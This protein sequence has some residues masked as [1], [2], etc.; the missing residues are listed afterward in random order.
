MIRERREK[1][2]DIISL[3]KIER[4][5]V[6]LVESIFFL[7]V[8]F[9]CFGAGIIATE[10]DIPPATGIVLTI[11]KIDS[12]GTSSPYD[13][14]WIEKVSS[15]DFGELKQVSGYTEGKKW[16]LFLP[17]YYFAVDIG[18]TGGG[19]DP[20]KNIV[21]EYLPEEE[22]SPPGIE[23]GLGDRITITY[24]RTKGKGK[25]TWDKIL[26]K[27]LFKESNTVPLWKVLGGWLRLYV[28]VV[29]KDPNAVPPDPPGAKVFTPSDPVGEYK[30]AIRISFF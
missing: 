6:L 11:T 19:F 26:E 8:S 14:Q 24:V 23:G 27:R 28:G 18:L 20:T 3:R 5:V 30:G 2:R 16:T 17:R 29:S 9:C 22:V 7:M 12:K 1:I 10:A 4:E 15:F 13:D 21:V 25:R